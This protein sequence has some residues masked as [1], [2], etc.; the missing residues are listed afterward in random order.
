MPDRIV[1]RLNGPRGSALLACALLAAVHALAYSPLTR[2]PLGLPIGL[3]LMSTVIPLGVYAILWAVTAV[4]CAVAAFRS[5]A[6]RD[7]RQR[8]ARW[9]FGAF[10]G[11]V[12]IWV[13]AYTAGWV[14]YVL[15]LADDG[16]ARAYISAGLY[17]GVLI[18]AWSCA[19]MANPVV[20]PGK[21]TAP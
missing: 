21:R 6:T 20:I 9:A 17:G 1:K 18:L 4:L 11:L 8:A 12:T 10:S 14:L 16:A 2:P 3:R 5:K 7:E 19:R 15:G 13:L